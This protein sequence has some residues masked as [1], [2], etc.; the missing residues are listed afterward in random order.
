MNYDSDARGGLDDRVI[1]R[2]A[3]K[4]IV[5]TESYEVA[6]SLFEQPSAFNIRLGHAGTAI[7]LIRLFPPGTPFELLIGG[8]LQYSGTFDGPGVSGDDY[9][10]VDFEGR[11]YL[12]VLHDTFI[13]GERRY[14][15][16][17]YR[18]LV[19]TQLKEAGVKDAK[20]IIS[21]V[22]ER[23]GRAGKKVKS[24]GEP[25]NVSELVVEKGKGNKIYSTVTSELGEKRLDFI[26][27]HLERAGLFLWAARNPN[28]FILG[29]PNG[30]QSP[31]YR[32]SRGLTHSNAKLLSWRNK[33][34]PPR[35]GR[36][37]IYGRSGGKKYGYARVKGEYVDPE[38]KAWGI[39]TQEI[40]RDADVADV[41]QA[42][43]HARYRCATARREQW[44]LSYE[45][46]GHTATALDGGKRPIWTIDTIVDVQD[47]VLGINGP[48]WISEV[49][50]RGSPEGTTTQISLMRPDDLVFSSGT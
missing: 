28:E 49:R 1:L 30:N 20:V 34:Q 21:N 7:E 45:V 26:R 19:E 18:E 36:Y 27:R 29:A 35:Y 11:D 41:A 44:T 14:N 23:S 6:C 38:M 24:A 2:A 13:D 25:R 46:D 47:D 32:I 33:P 15:H 8:V 50:Y 4:E 37:V 16:Q 9:T 39:D 5:L 43:Y 10:A 48:H 42:T 12:K 3:G 17:T 40:V 31:L 22:E